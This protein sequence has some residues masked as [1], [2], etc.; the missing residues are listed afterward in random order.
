MYSPSQTQVW[1]NDPLAWY[2]QYKEG[3]RTRV[4]D[5]PALSRIIGAAVADGAAVWYRTG[6]SV[7]AVNTAHK[8]VGDELASLRGLGHTVAPAVQDF[9]D[10]AP[11]LAGQIGRAHV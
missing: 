4:L 3:W 9:A 6:D 7:G 1:L 10:R 11:Q 8:A 5:K 2:L